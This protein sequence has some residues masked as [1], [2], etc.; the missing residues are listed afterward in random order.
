[1]VKQINIHLQEEIVIKWQIKKSNSIAYFLQR[2]HA[3]ELI[4]FVVN[5]VVDQSL[6]V[7]GSVVSNNLVNWKEQRKYKNAGVLL[8]ANT[9]H[10]QD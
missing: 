1:M 6:V 2:V 5:L 4:E 8:S 9:Y 3:A 7:I 10:W